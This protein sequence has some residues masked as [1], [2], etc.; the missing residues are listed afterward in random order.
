MTSP[1]GLQAM[2]AYWE[3]LHAINAVQVSEISVEVAPA[4]LQAATDRLFRK[5]QA[6]GPVGWP[7]LSPSGSAVGGDVK[8][9]FQV[10][11]QLDSHPLER[12][13]SVV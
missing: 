10:L 5:F 7:S 13:E 1:T 11:S 3:S 9:R 4:D 2:M 12:S 8:V 6:A